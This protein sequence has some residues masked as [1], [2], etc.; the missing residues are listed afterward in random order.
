MET[1]ILNNRP[2][3]VN[4]KTNKPNP[5]FYKLKLIYSGYINI[6]AINHCMNNP[7]SI[8][9]SE[10]QIATIINTSKMKY[11]DLLDSFFSQSWLAIIYRELLHDLYL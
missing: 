4:S 9:H 6:Y 7:S 5:D 8:L 2:V 11:I 1:V 3:G 10:R